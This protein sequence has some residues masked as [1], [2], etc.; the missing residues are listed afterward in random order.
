MN[1]SVEVLSCRS[2]LHDICR[3][4]LTAC[5]SSYEGE[6]GSWKNMSTFWNLEEDGYNLEVG[7]MLTVWK[8][9]EDAHSLEVRIGWLQ[10]GS[11]GKMV[12]VW[13]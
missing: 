3:I 7:E 6:Y 12:T 2:V 13:K 1:D 4:V 11:E 10:S 5:N 8:W 9:L